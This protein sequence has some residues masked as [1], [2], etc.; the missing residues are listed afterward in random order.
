[1][2]WKRQFAENGESA[3]SSARTGTAP[4]AT[5]SAPTLQFRLLFPPNWL[6]DITNTHQGLSVSLQV[7]LMT[8][9]SATHIYKFGVEERRHSELG[10]FL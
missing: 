4:V 7:V 5:G 1:M 9:P 3:G 8:F 2:T 10:L 6:G